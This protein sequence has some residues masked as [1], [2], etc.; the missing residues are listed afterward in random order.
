MYMVIREYTLSS[1]CVHSNA[2]AWFDRLPAGQS[3]LMLTAG[4]PKAARPSQAG[5]AT[6]ESAIVAA[7]VPPPLHLRVESVG[8]IPF[9][10]ST[11][12]DA[13]YTCITY[14][15]GCTASSNYA[16]YILYL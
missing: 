2:P 16:N 3:D 4:V 9:S 11:N 7:R 10:Y 1:E 8:C 12:V 5:R 14:Y 15:H 13:N 6:S